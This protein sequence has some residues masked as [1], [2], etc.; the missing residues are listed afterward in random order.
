MVL[1]L[2]CIGSRY[3]V[4]RPAFFSTA[5]V[6]HNLSVFILVSSILKQMFAFAKPIGSTTE[7]HVLTM[8]SSVPLSDTDFLMTL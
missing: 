7:I 2:G 6:V 4:L 3:D 5:V 1:I 8:F